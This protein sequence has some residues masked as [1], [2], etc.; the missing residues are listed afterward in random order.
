MDKL[1]IETPEQ[2]QLE[3]V[4][5]GIGSRFMALLLD[6]LVQSVLFL[7]L[8]IFVITVAANPFTSGGRIWV[9]AIGFLIGFVLYT[10]Y[11]AIQEAVWKGQTLGKRWAGIR[12]IK[13][14]GR[15]ITPF[16]A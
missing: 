6:T 13:D 16:E 15:P 11:F 5:A 1:T 3:F 12:V 8:F 10:G 2:V 14:S 9:I 4:L 7:I